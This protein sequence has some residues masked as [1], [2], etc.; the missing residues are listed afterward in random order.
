MS[1]HPAALAELAVQSLQSE[2]S[3]AQVGMKAVLA[4]GIVFLETTKQTAFRDAENCRIQVAGLHCRIGVLVIVRIANRDGQIPGVEF[5][6]FV[7]GNARDVQVA[8]RYANVEIR[9]FWHLDPDL[10]V[11]VRAA[12]DP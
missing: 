4:R 12:A 7:P 2:V 6:I 8:G 1:W 9:V 3:G 10:D 11:I 5:D